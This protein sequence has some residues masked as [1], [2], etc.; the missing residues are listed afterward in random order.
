MNNALPPAISNCAVWLLGGSV[1]VRTPALARTQFQSFVRLSNDLLEA[2]LRARLNGTQW[3]ILRGVI[4]QT[5][6]WNRRSTPFTWYKL[7]KQLC[8]DRAA[9][10]RAGQALLT[11]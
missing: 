6:G 1:W 9:V 10:Y 11:A 2:L 3:R 7:A 5:Y 4:R 8:L